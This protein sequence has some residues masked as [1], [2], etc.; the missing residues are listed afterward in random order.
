MKNFFGAFLWAIAFIVVPL[1]A[2]TIVLQPGNEGKDTYVCDCL[3]NVNNPNG[4]VTNLYQGQYGKCYDRLLIQWDLSPLPQDISITSAVM[5]LK[6]S[7][8][9][10]SLSGRMVYYRIVG[11]WE[12]TGVSFTGL[13]GHT[14]EDSVIADWPVS[15]Q[16]HAVDITRFVQKWVEDP[17]SNRGIY[18]HSAG[19]TGQCCIQFNSSDVSTVANHPKLTITYVTSSGIQQSADPQLLHFQ[20]GQ[21]YPNPF[22]PATKIRYSI[23]GNEFV[24]LKIF[25][26]QGNEVAVLVDRMQIPGVYEIVFD[27]K[28]LPS[29]IYQYRLQAGRLCE[30]KKLILIK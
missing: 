20:L 2:E 5:E 8:V 12:E 15:G 22:N 14:P 4:P 24:S 26:L 19:T 10:G 17:P 3:P 9:Y 28:E 16:W 27:G 13:P 21:N 29:G 7:G 25:D 1:S 11:E 23:P 6:C 30:V 18:G